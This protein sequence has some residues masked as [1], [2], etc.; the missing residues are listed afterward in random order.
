[1]SIKLKMLLTSV[2]LAALLG[3]TLAL[4]YYS[5]WKLNNGFQQV[6]VKAEAGVE[7]SKAA[8]AT[9][10]KADSGMAV[11][12]HNM[13]EIADAMAK[14]N[15][16]IRIIER[17]MKSISG[18][19]TDFAE[20]VEEIYDQLPEG[21]AKDT[22]EDIADEASDIQEMT[23]RE[24]LV[25]IASAAKSMNQFAQGLSQEVENIKS[26]S[27]ELDAGRSLSRKI[28]AGNS[29]IQSL[30]NTFRDDLKGNRNLLFLFLIALFVIVLTGSAILSHLLTKPINAAVEGLKDIAEGEGD[31]T[32]RLT[33][34]S[35]DEMGGDGPV[36]Q[37]L[38]REIAGDY[39]KNGRQLQ[40]GRSI[41]RRIVDHRD[42]VQLQCR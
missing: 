33:V 4:T 3:S 23:K 8:E 11:V 15:M 18:T 27:G 36:V 7:N 32:K 25:G 19:M 22:L 31:L 6:L 30:S 13:T 21:D 14:T 26:S 1:M 24:A 38:H 41:S 34:E 9:F 35:K 39:R 42:P 28:S 10:S 37:H 29:E 12:T 2:F 20:T 40:R 16:R 5:F 17:K